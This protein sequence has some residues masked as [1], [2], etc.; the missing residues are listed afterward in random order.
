MA[1]KFKLGE[2]VVLTE[3][4]RHPR[5]VAGICGTVTTRHTNNTTTVHFYEGSHQYY[6]I[7][8]DILISGTELPHKE[9]S[10]DLMSLYGG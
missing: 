4:W 7:N 3:D 9:F 5:Y 2:R 6:R 10:A 8:N 1:F